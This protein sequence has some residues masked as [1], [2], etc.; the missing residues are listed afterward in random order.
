MDI[1][2]ICLYLAEVSLIPLLILAIVK[3]F[4][5]TGV[6]YDLSVAVVVFSTLAIVLQ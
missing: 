4:I 3:M 5:V 6:L 1:S 2:D